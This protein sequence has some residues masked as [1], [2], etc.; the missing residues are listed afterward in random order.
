MGETVT[1]EI[2][3]ALGSRSEVPEVYEDDLRTGAIVRDSDDDLWYLG[4]PDNPGGKCHWYYLSSQGSAFDHPTV[5]DRREHLSPYYTP[6][7]LVRD[8]QGW[9]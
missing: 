9:R 4:Y 3:V 8:G 1:K 2:E 7:T 6:Y 5:E